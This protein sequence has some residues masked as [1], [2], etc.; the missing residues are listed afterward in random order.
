VLDTNPRIALVEVQ[1]HTDSDGSEAM[2]LDLSQRR[3]EAVRDYLIAKGIDGARL[4][5]RGY[6]EGVAIDTNATAAGK[7]NN[8]R[9]EFHIVGE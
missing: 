9:V 2:N 1:G 4:V 5:A 7:A 8:R 6:G 3:S